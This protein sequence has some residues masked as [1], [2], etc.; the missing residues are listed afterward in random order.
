MSDERIL[1][2]VELI[3]HG[4]SALHNGGFFVSEAKNLSFQ[5][6]DISFLP[7]AMI[8]TSLSMGG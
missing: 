7:V 8:S 1:E 2:H 4:P 3:S 5:G 6:F